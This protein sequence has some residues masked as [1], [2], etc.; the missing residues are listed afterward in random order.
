MLRIANVKTKDNGCG[1]INSKINHITNP[2]KTTLT[3]ILPKIIANAFSNF[4]LNEYFA[5]TTPTKT[6]IVHKSNPINDELNAESSSVI[7]CQL[8]IMS[9]VPKSH[10]D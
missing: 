8:H 1:F 2:D 7:F 3:A 9:C 6:L 5:T 4:S 10:F